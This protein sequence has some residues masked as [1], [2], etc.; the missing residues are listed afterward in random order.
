MKMYL[1]DIVKNTKLDKAIILKYIADITKSNLLLYDNKNG[2]DIYFYNSQYQHSDGNNY[3][4]LIDLSINK[5]DDI[6]KEEVE[7]RII[8]ERKLI[9]DAY[10]IKIIKPHKSMLKNELI[11]KVK[12][13]LKFKT[14]MDVIETRIKLL[15][16]NGYIYQKDNK[17]LI[18][19]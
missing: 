13:S 8:E 7:E 4:N 11:S 9:I 18:L 3:I 10:I 2:E 17:D 12:E 5:N 1:K 15:L 14:E 6:E 19:Y 16:E